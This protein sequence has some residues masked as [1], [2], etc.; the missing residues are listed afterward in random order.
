M[1]YVYL[2]SIAGVAL[3]LILASYDIACQFFPGLPRRIHQLPARLQPSVPLKN[4]VPKVPKAHIY[5]H[6]EKCHGPFS[7]NWTK[8][9][10][11]TDGEGIERLWSMLNKAALSVREMTPAARRETVD[12]L[13]G[14]INW[15]KV[16]NYGKFCL[17]YLFSGANSTYIPN[18]R[19]FPA[20]SS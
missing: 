7:F 12:D 6:N 4:I 1:D 9:A 18:R 3:L 14:F 16:I 15:C 20:S 5:T 11:R 10:G 8:G 13:C 2:S 19:F 17:M